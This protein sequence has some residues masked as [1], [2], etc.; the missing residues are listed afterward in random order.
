MLYN[1]GFAAVPPPDFFSFRAVATDLAELEGPLFFKRAPAY[2]AAMALG[3][4]L[5]PGPEPFLAAA[6]VVSVVAALGVLALT[7]YWTRPRLGRWAL[8]AAALVATSSQFPLLATLPLCEMLYLLFILAAV[9]A[10]GRGT[11]WA[12]VW[13]GAAAATRYEALALIPLVALCDVRAWRRRPR[14]LLYAVLAVVPGGGWLLA[15]YLRTGLLNPYVE[16]IRALGASGWAFPRALVASFFEPA[17]PPTWLLAAVFA[18]VTVTGLVK[19]A[20][21]GRAGDRAFLGFAV[22]YTLVHVIFPFSFRRFVFPLWPLLVL[23]F[24]EGGKTCCAAAARVRIGRWW[25]AVAGALFAVFAAGLAWRLGFSGG[26][27][28]G[29]PGIAGLIPLA[30]LLACVAWGW[31]GA[32]PEPRRWALAAAAATAVALFAHSNFGTYALERGAIRYDRASLKEAAL[33][34][35][36]AAGPGD[37]VV[38]ADGGVFNYYS[39]PTGPAFRRAGSFGT[40]DFALFTA[41][42]RRAGAAYVCYDSVSVRAAGG[43]FGEPAVA[44]ALQPLS[45]GRDVGPYRFIAETDAPGE[46]V[47]IYRLAVEPPGWEPPGWADEGE[48]G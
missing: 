31:A 7:Y 14:L 30:G 43:Y 17:G 2:P 13:A 15:G 9:A 26:E 48:E 1:Y 10:A 12:Y 35:A 45:A 36:R 46:F 16:E 34:L 23:A 20:A 38:A 41:R 42:A 47:Y 27:A 21:R 25:Y 4:L 28:A 24:L 8:L 11:G 33:W 39:G 3:R 5:A 19:I 32:R 40:G 22:I 29:P 6:N 44:Q 37:V 18:A